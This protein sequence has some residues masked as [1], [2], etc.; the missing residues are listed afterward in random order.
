[1]QVYLVLQVCNS[2]NSV[3][4]SECFA[5][6]H[7]VDSHT[8]HHIASG[9]HLSPHSVVSASKRAGSITAKITFLLVQVEVLSFF[10]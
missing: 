6:A 5:V 2:L 1:M 8:V 3:C 10:F 7:T 4:T 9:D